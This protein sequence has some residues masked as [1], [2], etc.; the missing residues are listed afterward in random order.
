MSEVSLLKSFEELEDPRIERTKKYPLN[1]IIL[2]I[3][4]A[5][6]S[7]CTGWKSIKVFGDEKLNWLRKYLPYENGIPVDDTIARIVRRLCPTTFKTCFYNWTQNISTKVNKDIIPVDGKRVRGSYDNE[8]EQSAIHMVSAWSDSNSVVL[9]QEK[10]SDKSNEITAIPK[11][12]D[13]LDVENCIVSIDS[14][15]CQKSIAEQIIKQKGDYVLGLKG[16]QGNLHDDVSYFFETAYQS[17]FI[18]IEHD[19]ACDIDSGH[20]RIEKRECW[21]VCPRS[22]KKCFKNFNDWKKLESIVMIKS[23]RT[24]K[25]KNST[26]TR[27]YI[28]SCSADASYLNKVIRKHWGVESMHWILDVTFREDESRIRKG[29]APENISMLRHLALNAMKKFTGIK[30]SI[31]GKVQRALL[32][33]DFRSNVL[34]EVMNISVN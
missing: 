28:S 9:G 18:N 13:M 2:L 21:T 34:K 16:N 8:S 14:M 24:T 31:A 32:S 12:L 27:F 22:Y 7:G 23:T 15:G 11:L 4:S 30:D 20:G 3:V 33:D 17:D 10:V 19:Y 26:E 6:I 1:E 29:D 5:A 25:S